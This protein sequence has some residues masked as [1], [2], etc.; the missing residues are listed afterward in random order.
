MLI[1][2]NS[3][4]DSA[5]VNN[6]NSPEQEV[7][8][9]SSNNNG[10]NSDETAVGGGGATTTNLNSKDGPPPPTQ[11]NKINYSPGVPLLKR[12]KRQSSSRFNIPKNRELQKLP[13]LRGQFIFAFECLLLEEK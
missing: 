2:S 6:S 11:I 1:Q 12:E 3:N 7:I 8:D 4:Q 13:L 9:G 10:N 5:N